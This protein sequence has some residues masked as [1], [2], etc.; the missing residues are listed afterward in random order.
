MSPRKEKPRRI[1][2]YGI[3][4]STLVAASGIWFF[5]GLGVRKDALPVLEQQTNHYLDSP[6]G[7]RLNLMSKWHLGI[8]QENCCT[9]YT[10]CATLSSIIDLYL[11]STFLL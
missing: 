2:E 6:N 7:S 4:V 1:E 10:L 8:Q 5:G 11:C 9:P 3:E